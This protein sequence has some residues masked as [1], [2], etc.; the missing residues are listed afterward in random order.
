MQMK[1]RRN[2]P[3]TD[4][5]PEEGPALFSGEEANIPPLDVEISEK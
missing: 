4:R 2:A 3:Q 1:S 5:S